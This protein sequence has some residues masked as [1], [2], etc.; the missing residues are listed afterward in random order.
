MDTTELCGKLFHILS[1]QT[2]VICAYEHLQI[3][4]NYLNLKLNFHLFFTQRD[5]VEMNV[6]H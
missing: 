3:I 1:Y 2:E 4:F 6:K 5:L